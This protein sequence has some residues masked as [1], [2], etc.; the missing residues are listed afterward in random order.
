MAVGFSPR[1]CRSDVRVVERRLSER[2]VPAFQAS[3]RDARIYAF[4][5]RAEARGDRQGLALR[6]FGLRQSSGAFSPGPR[7]RKRQRAAAVQDASATA[8]VWLRFMVP[9]H[10]REREETLE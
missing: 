3:L 4:S 7:A 5:P 8:A 10:P 6:G 2:V 9:T 1:N